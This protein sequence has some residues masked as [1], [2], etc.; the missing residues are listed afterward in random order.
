MCDLSGT[1]ISL[2]RVLKVDTDG[3][4]MKYCELEHG[5]E[6]V[7]I[8]LSVKTCCMVKVSGGDGSSYRFG[9]TSSGR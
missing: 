5:F 3:I 1:Y 4:K 8:I 9:I 7:K 6:K 2:L